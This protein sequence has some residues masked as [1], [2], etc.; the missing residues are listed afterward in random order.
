MLD[1]HFPFHIIQNIFFHFRYW[2]NTYLRLCVFAFSAIKFLLLFITISLC[3]SVTVLKLSFKGTGLFVSLRNILII[4]ILIFSIHTKWDYGA[5][6]NLTIFSALSAFSAGE[7]FTFKC[8][9]ISLDTI[10]QSPYT[11]TTNSRY[12]KISASLCLCIL[13]DKIFTAIYHNLF[14]S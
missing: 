1:F 3:L 8:Q 2:R 11:N 7:I 14:V 12:H 5:E 4:N 10:T 9:T 13:C 6:Q